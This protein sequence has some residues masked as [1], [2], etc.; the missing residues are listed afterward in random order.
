[1]MNPDLLNPGDDGSRP[2]VPQTPHITKPFPVAIASDYKHY[3]CSVPAAS[4]HRTDGKKLAFVGG[5]LATNLTHDQ[6]YLDDEIASG[7]NDYIR[8]ARPEEIRAFEMKMDPRGTLTKEIRAEMEPEIRARVEAD[9]RTELEAKI[10]A[11]L[12]AGGSSFEEGKKETTPAPGSEDL[13][14]VQG[15]DAATRAK[16]LLAQSGMKGS[17]TDAH[18]NS[19]VMRSVAAP[20]SGIVSTKDIGGGAAGSASGATAPAAPSSTPAK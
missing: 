10:R 20:L 15:I 19:I 7:M 3:I 8:Y 18:G 1:M 5:Y 13:S 17:T 9:L 2:S 11:E 16:E 4:F 14:K 12:A 6:Q